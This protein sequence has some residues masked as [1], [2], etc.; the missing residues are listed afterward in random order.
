[1]VDK[2]GNV[3]SATETIECYYGSGVT[4]PGLGL[5][6]N[7]EMHDFDIAPGLP[8]SVAPLKRPTSSM[9][10]TIVLKDDE[11]F[12]VLGSAGS[13]RIISSVFQTV[14]NVTEGGMSL[15]DAVASPRIHPAAGVLE[16]E[17]GSGRKEILELR[18]AGYSTHLRQSND[19]YFGG[20]QAIMVA[21]QSGKLIGAADPRRKGVAVAG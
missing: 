11:P 14:R 2:D 4:I 6:M 16:V 19:Y 17:G 10:P 12:L 9:A 7:D 1:V 18:K 8:N 21:H 3:V 20:V 15:V 5:I 13:G